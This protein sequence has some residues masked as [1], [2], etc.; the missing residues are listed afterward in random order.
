MLGLHE[1]GRSGN[2]LVIETAASQPAY[3]GILVLIRK[4]HIASLI[5]DRAPCRVVETET[6]GTWRGEGFHAE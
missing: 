6:A 4:E 3:D 1:R 2:H 5:A